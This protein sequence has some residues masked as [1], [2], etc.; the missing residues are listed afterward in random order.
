MAALVG[1]TFSQ[2]EHHCRE[3]LYT[4]ADE[5]EED[6]MIIP[7]SGAGIKKVCSESCL[8]TAT[9]FQKDSADLPFLSSGSEGS[10]LLTPS[11]G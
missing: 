4:C 11:S 8:D 6:H 9:A 10:C 1:C 5:P 3:H 2:F 7:S